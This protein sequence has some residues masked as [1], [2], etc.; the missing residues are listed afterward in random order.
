MERIKVFLFTDAT[1]LWVESPKEHLSILK[2]NLKGM[3]YLEI[4]LTREVLN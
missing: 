1:M 4:S 2:Y 3:K